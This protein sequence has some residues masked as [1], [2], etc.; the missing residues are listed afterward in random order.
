MCIARCDRLIARCD[1]DGNWCTAD[2]FRSCDAI[3]AEC[4]CALTD[5]VLETCKCDNSS[6]W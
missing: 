6:V 2:W 5:L 3:D 4:H 1:K